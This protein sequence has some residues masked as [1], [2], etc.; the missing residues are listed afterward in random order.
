MFITIESKKPIIEHAPARGCIL[1]DTYDKNDNKIHVSL[2]YICEN[3]ESKIKYQL[4]QNVLTAIKAI[5]SNN[6]LGDV[7]TKL[8]PAYNLKKYF[9][10]DIDK[11]TGFKKTP[12]KKQRTRS[13]D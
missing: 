4:G 11:D 6:C 1:D 8:S 2:G 3:C 13:Q 7:N 10:V 5:C 9:R 12:W